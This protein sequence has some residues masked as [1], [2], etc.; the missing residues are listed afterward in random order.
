MK[1]FNLKTPTGLKDYILKDM[2]KKNKIESALKELFLSNG[3]NLIE[4][5]TLEYIDVFTDDIQDTSLYKLTNKEGEVLALKNDITKSIARVVRTFT[6]DFIFP[7]RFCYISNIFRCKKAYQGMQHEFTQ[8]GIELIGA[9]DLYADYEVV[10]LAVKSLNAVLDNF[11]LYISSSE[12]FSNYLDDLNIKG[13][14]KLEILQA[15]KNKNISNVKKIIDSNSSNNK[16]D[17]KVLSLVIEAIG[18]KDLLNQIKSNVKSDKTLA[19]LTRLEKLYDLLEKN[20]LEKNVSFDFSILSFG[21]YYTGITLQGYTKGVGSPIL[22]GG[23]YDNLIG[24]ENEKISA[25]GFAININ[26]LI[27]KTKLTYE[28]DVKLIYSDD[29]EKALKFSNENSFVSLE[30]CI[31]DAFA[32]G[33]ANNIKEIVDIDTNKKYKLEGGKYICQ[34]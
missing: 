31:E 13:C 21:D 29:K 14:V 18:K 25:C 11:N 30:K 15:I 8:A 6:K 19:S 10:S 20:G 24:D 26:D 28:K 4:T 23:R 34:E 16:E 9:S 27:N 12:F 1:T 2:E 32:Y 7:Q 22:D 3:Y 17:Y 5:P 33:L